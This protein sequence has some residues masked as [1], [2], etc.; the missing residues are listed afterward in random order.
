MLTFLA[1]S[2]VA[3]R[4]LLHIPLKIGDLAGLQLGTHLKFDGSRPAEILHLALQQHE[5]KNHT[6]LEWSVSTETAAFLDRYLKRFHPLLAKP[7]SAW[8][9]PGRGGDNKISV[10]G[11]RYHIVRIVADKIGAVVTPTSSGPL[12]PG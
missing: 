6:N 3:L 5:T 8:L 2:A 1:R 12:P 9:F 11:L 4:I 7:G 10:D